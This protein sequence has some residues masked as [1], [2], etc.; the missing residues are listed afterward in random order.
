MEKSVE[1][2]LSS[3][4]TKDGPVAA[5][6]DCNS[7]ELAT[8]ALVVDDEENALP[9]KSSSGHSSSR[10]KSKRSKS[11]KKK[12]DKHENKK[13]SK[14]ENSTG[15]VNDDE[16]DVSPQIDGEEPDVDAETTANPTAGEALSIETQKTSHRNIFGIFGYKKDEAVMPTGVENDKKTDSDNAAAEN[17]AET[18]AEV[19]PGMTESKN[20]EKTEPAESSST[21]QNFWSN[22]VGNKI[23]KTKSEDSG[24]ALGEADN[25][26]PTSQENAEDD[27]K[28]KAHDD[29]KKALNGDAPKVAKQ[30]R[31]KSPGRLRFWSRKTPKPDDEEGQDDTKKGEIP[32][33]SDDQDEGADSDQEEIEVEQSLNDWILSVKERH[34]HLAL[35]EKER[36]QS[37]L[38]Q[39]TALQAYVQVYDT[40]GSE[41]IAEMQRLAIF[42]DGIWT[43]Q[44]RFAEIMQEKK[45]QMLISKGGTSETKS[46]GKSNTSTESSYETQNIP[47]THIVGDKEKQNLKDG[48]SSLTGSSRHEALGLDDL[49]DRWAMASD[50]P[51][52][53]FSADSLP[54]LPSKLTPLLDA[55][56]VSHDVWESKFSDNSQ[57]TRRGIVNVLNSTWPPKIRSLKAELD[58]LC[59]EIFP[60]IVSKQS[61]IQEAWGESKY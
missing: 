41:S 20:A 33:T 28:E 27:D 25:A 60:T 37:F 47:W 8:G 61:S 11:S 44:K 13:I 7:Q 36:H 24:S 51:P 57:Q 43:A 59:E 16:T 2:D 22:F 4:A 14:A 26:E 17:E 19:E 54:I 1:A 32:N 52:T 18:A 34:E 55:M 45:R 21:K 5:D 39:W 10:K 49:S 46:R 58:N 12:H 15:L 48:E 50:E 30:G 23:A 29:I 42:V 6:E 3:D 31:P 9:K 53:S 56:E 38:S 35:F 40:I